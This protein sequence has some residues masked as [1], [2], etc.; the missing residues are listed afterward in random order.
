MNQLFSMSFRKWSTFTTLCMC[1]VH[2]RVAEQQYTRCDQPTKSAR[3]QI[4]LKRILE[5]FVSKNE[6]KKS[7]KLTKYIWK[8]FDR[9][10]RKGRTCTTRALRLLLIVCNRHTV[11][12]LNRHGQVASDAAETTRREEAR[13]PC[14]GSHRSCMQQLR[15]MS[16]GS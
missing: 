4:S 5:K 1:V 11:K 3:T 16:R 6:V 13:W 10:R 9:W 7:T 15:R 12:C 14:H 2:A 8:E